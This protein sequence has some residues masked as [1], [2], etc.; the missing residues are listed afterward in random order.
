MYAVNAQLVKKNSLG[1]YHI[2]Y[3]DN[4]KLIT[5]WVVMRVLRTHR[6]CRAKTASDY[7]CT[8]Y[9]IFVRINSFAGTDKIVPPA[10]FFV[11]LICSGAVVRTG[12]RMTND[13][14]IAFVAV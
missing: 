1:F 12:K 3:C 5:V 10:R 14:D 2:F 8:N 9:K 7:I 4:R 11:A 13:N 6:S